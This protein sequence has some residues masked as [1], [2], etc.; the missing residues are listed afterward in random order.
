MSDAAIVVAVASRLT[1]RGSQ[2]LI[3]DARSG[4]SRP[5]SWCKRAFSVSSSSTL[6]SSRMTLRSSSG[7]DRTGR[8]ATV[9]NDRTDGLPWL[10]VVGAAREDRS[11]DWRQTA[12]RVRQGG[13]QTETIRSGK[14]YR[15]DGPRGPGGQGR[16]ESTPISRSRDLTNPSVTC[17]YT[18]GADDGTRTR[19]PHLGKVM[20]YQL[21]HVR[22]VPIVPSRPPRTH[23]A[24]R[25]PLEGGATCDCFGQN[26][27]EWADEAPRRPPRLHQRARC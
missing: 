23:A 22:V 7:G 10:T 11:R 9:R 2:A 13:S 5:S 26:P 14:Q 20:L 18:T 3:V 17:A 25:P 8:E 15:S 12:S 6:C 24:R 1:S 4:L 27:R 19:D 21:S 16:C